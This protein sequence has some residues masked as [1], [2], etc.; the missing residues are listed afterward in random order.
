[1]VK[2]L[3]IDSEVGLDGADHNILTGTLEGLVQVGPPEVDLPGHLR[4]GLLRH[5]DDGR[6]RPALRHRPL[7]HGGLPGLAPAGRPR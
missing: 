6:R 2:L 1:M 7:R 5:R 3:G 4:P